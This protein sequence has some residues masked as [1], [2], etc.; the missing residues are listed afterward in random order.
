MFWVRTRKVVSILLGYCLLVLA[1]SGVV[2]Y[3][4]PHG[5]Y[6]NWNHWTLWGLTKG[7]WENVHTIVG[8]LMVILSILHV[9]L[10]WRPMI[11]YLKSRSKILISQEFIW[12]TVFFILIIWGTIAYVPP[13][14]TIMDAGENFSNSWEK[15]GGNPSVPHMELM[16]MEELSK[17]KNVSADSIV[18]ILKNNGYEC[19]M[20]STLKDIGEKY[21]VSPSLLND[22]IDRSIDKGRGNGYGRGREGDSY[23]E[24]GREEDYRGGGAG[25]YGRMTVKEAA[26]QLGVDKDVAIMRLKSKGIEAD[27][28]SNLRDLSD[29]YNLRPSEVY[30]IIGGN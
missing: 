28:N 23:G 18:S 21:N 15:R 20:N 29:K 24:T 26:D 7:D 10:N 19:D 6:A 27:E 2:L 1:V 11:N 14:S 16:T 13:F 22:I 4:A 3:I 30:D 9:Y 8:Y 25:G 5:R 12:S 17:Y